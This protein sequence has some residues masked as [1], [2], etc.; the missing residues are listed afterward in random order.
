MAI[1]NDRKIIHKM[2]ENGKPMFDDNGKPVLM[3]RP[4]RAYEMMLPPKKLKSS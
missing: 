1:A 3:H 2:D 4:V